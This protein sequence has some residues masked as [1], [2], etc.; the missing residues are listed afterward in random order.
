M[1][2]MSV[3]LTVIACVFSAAA[4]EDGP[5]SIIQSG[6]TDFTQLLA[7]RPLDLDQL[8]G[9]HFTEVVSK[10]TWKELGVTWKDMG[11]PEEYKNPAVR[12]ADF[13]R[14]EKLH[15]YMKR[16]NFMTDRYCVSNYS[17]FLLFFNRGFVFRVELRYIPDTFRGTISPSDPAFCA[18]ET[19]I[20]NMFAGQLGRT[21]IDRPGSREVT[22]Y[23]TKYLMKLSAGGR[24]TD[25]AWDLRGGPSLRNF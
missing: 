14:A 6:N 11:S 5:L 25:L 21:I 1:K 3:L 10:V 4:A 7:F 22:K 20:F 12:Y 17:M 15:D 23:T 9:R 24:M 16:W 18:D 2:L 13:V 8:L 19:P